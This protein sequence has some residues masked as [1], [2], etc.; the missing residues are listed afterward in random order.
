ML[1]WN[2]T[3]HTAL[4]HKYF[5]VAD[6]YPADKH[7]I[8]LYSTAKVRTILLVRASEKAEKEFEDRTWW[9]KLSEE[10]RRA[11]HNAGPIPMHVSDATG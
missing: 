5:L 9:K 6:S 10:A 8:M 4:I 11:V 3:A 2:S 1:E 7:V